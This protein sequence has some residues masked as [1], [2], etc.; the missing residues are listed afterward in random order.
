MDKEMRKQIW[1][2]LVISFSRCKEHR[3][4]QMIAKTDKIIKYSISNLRFFREMDYYQDMPQLIQL[5]Y[6]YNLLVLFSYLWFYYSMAFTFT[7]F[8]TL[9]SVSVLCLIF[10]YSKREYDRLNKSSANI[11][12]PCKEESTYAYPRL[13]LSQI[14]S[15]LSGGFMYNQYKSRDTQSLAVQRKSFLH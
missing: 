8:S 6:N 14:H 3:P 7:V 1:E 11:E 9:L 4:T 5:L 2:I 13:P 12:C 15:L 10:S